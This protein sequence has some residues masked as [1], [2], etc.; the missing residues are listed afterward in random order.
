M[1]LKL[2]DLVEN[3]D[4]LEDELRKI[5]EKY[6]LNHVHLKEI[7][8]YSSRGLNQSD[9]SKKVGV[10]RNTVRKYVDKLKNMDKSDFKKIVV[11]TSLL[12]G[13]MYFLYDMIKE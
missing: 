6:G 2:S 4:V 8:R 12:F 5:A 9:I 10:S 1:G 13:G 11:I 3:E 7:V